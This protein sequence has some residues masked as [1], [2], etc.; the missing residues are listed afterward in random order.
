MKSEDGRKMLPD[1]IQSNLPIIGESPLRNVHRQPISHIQLEEVKQGN[2]LEDTDI[3]FALQKERK[4]LLPIL[5]HE[6]GISFVDKFS[7]MNLASFTSLKR[8]IHDEKGNKYFLKQKPS[9]SLDEPR[10]T[11]SAL[12]QSTL[13]D[14][15]PF[16]PPILFTRDDSPYA[17]IGTRTFLLT[18]FVEGDYYIGKHEQSFA[19]ARALAEIHKY[20]GSVLPMQS[21]PVDFT[22]ETI[23]FIR[24]V[25]Q[26]DFPALDLKSSVVD[27]MKE[28]IYVYR[29]SN[30]GKLGWLHGD[31]APSNMVFQQDNLVAVNDFDNV[32]YGVLSRDIAECL[33]THCDINYAGSMSSLRVPIRTSIDVDRM[34]KMIGFYLEASSLKKYDI[35]DMPKQMV[36]VWIELMSLGL[37]RGDFSLRDVDTALDHANDIYSTGQHLMKSSST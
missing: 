32:T 14:Y 3:L 2:T 22:E 30:E 4:N 35:I 5:S 8:I 29:S 7:D 23:D 11:R 12:M 6:Y 26:V 33:I 9:Y 31:F 25:E 37:A 16:V 1:Y 36:L 13:S 20:S 28:K 34:E 21:D 10:R 18:K 15:L 19:C 27:H 24:L 17:Q